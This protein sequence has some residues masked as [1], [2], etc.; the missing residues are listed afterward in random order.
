VSAIG[1]KGEAIGVLIL[2]GVDPRARLGDADGEATGEAMG[3][4]H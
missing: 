2:M 3:L 1:T 4:A